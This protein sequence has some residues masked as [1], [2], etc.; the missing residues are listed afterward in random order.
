MSNDL[1]KK[2][3]DTLR[4]ILDR[5]WD[6]KGRTAALG[7]LMVTKGWKRLQY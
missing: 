5:K 1:K 2:Y 4:N 3:I 7:E 6:Y